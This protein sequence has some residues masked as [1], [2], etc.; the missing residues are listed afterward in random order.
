VVLLCL[1]GCS[2]F[3]A[4]KLVFRLKLVRAVECLRVVDEFAD[5]AADA[6]D[7]A[8]LLQLEAVILGGRLR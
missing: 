3:G 4:L 2:A 8:M 7:A 1:C 6:V 5:H